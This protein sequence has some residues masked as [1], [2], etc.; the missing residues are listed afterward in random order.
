[1]FCNIRYMYFFNFINILFV[2]DMYREEEIGLLFGDWKY[3]CKGEYSCEEEE[4][5]VIIYVG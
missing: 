2:L 3:D 5:K 1:M 4:I